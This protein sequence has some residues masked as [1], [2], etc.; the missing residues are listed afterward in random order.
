L[1]LAPVLESISVDVSKIRF[2]FL[3]KLEP[4]HLLSDHP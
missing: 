1:P 2:G 3:G 4:T